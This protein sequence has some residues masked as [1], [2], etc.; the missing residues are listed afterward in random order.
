[1]GIF[2]KYALFNTFFLLIISLFIYNA[3]AKN[4]NNTI[5]S[6]RVIMVSP[7]APVVRVRLPSNPSTGYQWLLVKYDPALMLP[8]NSY[9]VPAKTDMMG[10]PGYT[11]WCFQF[12]R[13]A[14]SYPQKTR[15]LLEYK[16]PWEKTAGR[17]QMINF[18]I[19][20]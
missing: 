3:Y 6:D 13:T 11:I 12:K 2:R 16:R 7:L 15:V 20:S 1:M 8:P 10:A 19:S 5:S 14:F 4:I 18:K 17:Q 9:Y